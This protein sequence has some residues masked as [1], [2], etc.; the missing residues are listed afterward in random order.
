MCSFVENSFNVNWSSIVLKTLLLLP[1]KHITQYPY[2]LSLVCIKET[3]N[4]VVKFTHHEKQCNN[5]LCGL[6][7]IKT[8][9]N[10]HIF[11]N[12]YFLFEYYNS[13]A[14]I[15]PPLPPPF[16]GVWISTKWCLICLWCLFSFIPVHNIIT[17]PFASLHALTLFG[18]L[19]YDNIYWIY[20][21][22]FLCTSDN[23]WDIERERDSMWHT[24]ES[25]NMLYLIVL[26]MKIKVVRLSSA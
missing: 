21:S 20:S 9:K 22:L 4:R 23:I 8:Y 13:T 14:R 25:E 2:I 1:F 24:T 12:G 18:F 11:S 19:L 10:H 17:I 7:S 15:L 16:S 26:S 3:L 5:V 6:L